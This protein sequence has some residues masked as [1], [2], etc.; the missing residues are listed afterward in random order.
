MQNLAEITSVSISFTKKQ[1]MI[2]LTLTWLRSQIPVKRK[3]WEDK[4]WDQQTLCLIPWENQQKYFSCHGCQMG[5]ES[6]AD[7]SNILEY[8]SFS[9]QLDNTTEP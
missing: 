6:W 2:C 7:W 9:F 8:Q 5:F 1:V 3:D 4:K